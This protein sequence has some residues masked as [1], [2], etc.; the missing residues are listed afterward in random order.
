MAL[1]IPGKSRRCAVTTSWK[2]DGYEIERVEVHGVFSRKKLGKDI[3]APSAPASPG[4]SGSATVANPPASS[5]HE[6]GLPLD[7]FGQQENAG[8][9]IRLFGQ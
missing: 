9:Q 5:C 2:D 1:A 7:A 3:S 4:V 6:R 8:E